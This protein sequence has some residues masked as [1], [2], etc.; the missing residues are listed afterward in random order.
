MSVNWVAVVDRSGDNWLDYEYIQEQ[1]IKEP[2]SLP[3]RRDYYCVIAAAK[4]RAF[5]NSIPLQTAV[6]IEAQGKPEYHS[7]ITPI[8]R[9][10][11]EGCSTCGGGKVL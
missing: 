10:L 3:T 4:G 7:G 1:C 9:T 6:L 5:K 11:E 8:I 2:C